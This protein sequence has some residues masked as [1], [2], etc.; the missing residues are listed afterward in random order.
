MMTKTQIESLSKYEKNFKTAIEQDYSSA[1]PVRD[2]ILMK[3]MTGYDGNL[4]LSC[5]R[6]TMKLLKFVGQIYFDSKHELEEQE[7]KKPKRGRPKKESQS[8]SNLNN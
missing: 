6:C 7:E 8:D 4:N 5:S 3:E 2:L 1:I